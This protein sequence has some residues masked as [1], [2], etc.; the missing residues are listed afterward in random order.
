M[1]IFVRYIKKSASRFWNFS[2]WI[3]PLKNE[4]W[5]RLITIYSILTLTVRE[6]Q[7]ILEAKWICKIP[8]THKAGPILCIPI[9]YT[10]SSR[11]EMSRK[12]RPNSHKVFEIFNIVWWSAWK[13][14]GITSWWTLPPPLSPD[15]RL[16]QCV[17]W[18]LMRLPRSFTTPTAVPP[19]SLRLACTKHLNDYLFVETICCR[20]FT[21]CRPTEC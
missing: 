19:G 12:A 3:W 5:C 21:H 17:Y 18:K 8:C 4:H 14:F 10:V 13:F 9:L 2:G 16:E 7:C 6:C 15:T 11:S 20:G 1:P